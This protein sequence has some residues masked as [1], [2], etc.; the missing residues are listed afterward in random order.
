MDLWDIINFEKKE[1]AK[2][3]IEFAK[4]HKKARDK[5]WMDMCLWEIDKDK[6][7]LYIPGETEFNER[8]DRYYDRYSSSKK[9]CLLT[10]NP[11]MDVP[12]G[13]LIQQTEKCTKKKWFSDY[14]YCYEQRSEN[15]EDLGKGI[16]MHMLFKCG[17]KSQRDIKK[18]V[19][20]TFKNMV[21]NNL[22]INF[23]FTNDWDG[24][25]KY[26]KGNKSID[27]LRKVECDKLWRIGMELLDYYEKKVS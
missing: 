14:I 26:I 16:H 9:Y 27:K 25:E 18:E 24:C 17:K 1:V 11:N 6:T 12:L 5:K 20:N 2:L 21:K 10:V 7:R 23:K 13:Y 22:A 19:Y 3:A 15:M 8:V 4:I